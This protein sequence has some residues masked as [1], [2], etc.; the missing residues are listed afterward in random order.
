MQ[1]SG[2]SGTYWDMQWARKLLVRILLM[3]DIWVVL[4]EK[5]TAQNKKKGILLY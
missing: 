3:T 5:R 2:V 1:S 4:F